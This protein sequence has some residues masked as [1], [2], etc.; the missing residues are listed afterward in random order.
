[1][2]T[3]TYQ[4]YTINTPWTA[5]EQGNGTVDFSNL[6][7]GFIATGSNNSGVSDSYFTVGLTTVTNVTISFDWSFSSNDTGGVFDPLVVIVN[8]QYGELYSGSNSTASGSFSQSFPAGTTFGIGILTE[9]DIFGS[10][11][12]VIS[13]III[14]VAPY[15]CPMTD[16]FIRQFT[17]TDACGNTS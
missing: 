7:S 6:P 13:N 8:N 1:D 14:S 2:T 4:D 15:E 3:V 11:S 10:A 12:V 16:A 5:F 9:D 17:A